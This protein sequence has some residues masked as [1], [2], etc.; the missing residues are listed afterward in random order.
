MNYRA[1]LRWGEGQRTCKKV[2]DHWTSGSGLQ[3]L[4]VALTKVVDAPTSHE[5][6][7]DALSDIKVSPNIPNTVNGDTT[8]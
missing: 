1:T 3:L 8:M 4:Y 6:G 5:T 7:Q 2:K